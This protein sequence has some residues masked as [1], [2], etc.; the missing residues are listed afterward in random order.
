MLMPRE[1]WEAQERRRNVRWERGQDPDQETN[2]EEEKFEEDDSDNNPAQDRAAAAREISPDEDIRSQTIAMYRAIL[3]VS[4][5]AP[6]PLYNDQGLVRL[7]TLKEAEDKMVDSICRALTKPGGDIQGHLIPVLLQARLKL[8]AFW[9]RHMWRTSRVPKDWL[10]T[11]YED[12]RHLAPQKEMEDRYRE[13]TA[14]TPPELPLDQ[15]TAVAAFVHMRAYLRKLRGKTSGIPL[16]YVIRVRIKGSFDLPDAKEPDPPPFGSADSPYVSFDDEMVARAPILKTDLT[17]AQLSQDIEAL[18]KNEPFEQSFIA[19]SV[20]VYDIIHT[21]WGKLSWWTHCK[22]FDKAKNGCQAY[23]T[24]HSQLLGGKQLVSSGNAITTKIQTLRYDGDKTRFTFDKYVQLH[25]DLHYAHKDLEEYD[26]PPFAESMKILWFEQG[27]K[28]NALDAVKASIMTQPENYQTFQAVQDAYVD[29]YCRMTITDPPRTRQVATVRAGR[30]SGSARGC[31]G[32]GKTDQ[33][34]RHGNARAQGVFT[35][36]ELGACAIE[37]RKYSPDEY[38]CLTPL[39][40]QK[41][42]ILRNPGKTPGQG[43]TRHDKDKASVASTLTAS[44]SKR[45]HEDLEDF[46]SNVPSDQDIP[47]WGRNQENP[48]VSGRQRMNEG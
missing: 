23:R 7:E 25:V 2:D 4:P 10:G 47:A 27:I 12:I 8:L 29:Y 44:T 24:L 38:K 46:P 20:K 41:L 1:E 18:E 28:T 40:Q 45:T 33:G 31:T 32:G 9:V 15:T 11:S 26:V 39:Q 34:K 3:M 36:A 13:S 5:G 19:D 14:P 21:V 42:W 48:A 30:R 35:K 16:D 37:N 17:T 6:G 22:L 43:S